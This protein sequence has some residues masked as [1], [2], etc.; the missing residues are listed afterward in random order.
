MVNRFRKIIDRPAVLRTYYGKN[1]TSTSLDESIRYTYDSTEM[2]GTL[3]IDPRKYMTK[4]MCFDMHQIG[5][6]LKVQALVYYRIK[7]EHMH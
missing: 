5:V 4:P 1:V 3:S 2:S 7:T 6:S